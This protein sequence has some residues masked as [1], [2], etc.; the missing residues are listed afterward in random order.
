MVNFQDAVPHLPPRINGFWRPS[1]EVWQQPSD[2]DGGSRYWLCE[3]QENLGCSD[4]AYS[5]GREVLL[6]PYFVNQLG[7]A[8]HLGPYVNVTLVLSD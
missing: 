2:E 6:L 1:W 7:V 3:G 8:Q 5:P 4:Q